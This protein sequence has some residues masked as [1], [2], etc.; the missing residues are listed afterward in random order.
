MSGILGLALA[1]SVSANLA[2]NAPEDFSRENRPSIT[3]N[4][5]D[6]LTNGLIQATAGSAAGPTQYLDRQVVGGGALFEIS[7]SFP[8]MDIGAGAT[9]E[10]LGQTFGS[11]QTSA[12]VGYLPLNADQRILFISPTLFSGYGSIQGAVSIRRRGTAEVISRAIAITVNN[13]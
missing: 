12:A 2:W 7:A 11:G 3:G 13:G 8:L 10:I 9:V 4:G 5:W 1:R 6:F